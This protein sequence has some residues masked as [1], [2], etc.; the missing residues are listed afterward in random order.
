[1]TKFFRDA[2]AFDALRSQVIPNILANKKAGDTVKIWV[3]A[4]SSGE[5]AYSIAIL[6][7]E[8]LE[9]E[10][11]TI[12]TVKVF[13]SDIDSEALET[14]SRGTYIAVLPSRATMKRTLFS[15]PSR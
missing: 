6:V 5:E 13:A 9:R 4:C 8:Y 7:Q 12:L 15:C 2:E 11:I 10:K 3:V 14:A 1:M